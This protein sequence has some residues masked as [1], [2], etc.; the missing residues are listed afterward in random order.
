MTWAPCPHG[1]RTRGKKGL[2]PDMWYLRHGQEEGAGVGPAA[3]AGIRT[4]LSLW[5]L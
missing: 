3:L 4:A 2:S 1:V 5:L